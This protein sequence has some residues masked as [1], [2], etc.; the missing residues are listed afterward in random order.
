MRSLPVRQPSGVVELIPLP[1]LAD[2]MAATASVGATPQASPSSARTSD[3][4]SL[5]TT[6]GSVVTSLPARHSRGS[7]SF[8]G[9]ALYRAYAHNP[10]VGASLDRASRAPRDGASNRDSDG[11]ID[12]DLSP[13]CPSA[14]M[15]SM[16][17]GC[18]SSACAASSRG[19]YPGSGVPQRRI[20]GGAR[21]PQA[22]YE[23]NDDPSAPVVH[24]RQ[25]CDQVRSSCPFLNLVF[26]ISTSPRRKIPL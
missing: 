10:G 19:S 26:D 6:Q 16:G 1:T 11:G 25:I 8:R 7:S 14:A 23:P 4:N 24:V 3:L 18:T 22:I 15:M 17:V 20:P 9:L 5:A 12:S 13:V 2:L 21:R